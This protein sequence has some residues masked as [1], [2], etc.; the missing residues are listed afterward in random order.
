MLRCTN[1]HLIP[2]AMKRYSEQKE[3][4]ARTTPRNY[5]PAWELDFE[6]GVFDGKERNLNTQKSHKCFFSHIRTL[7][8]RIVEVGSFATFKQ[9]PPKHPFSHI[10]IDDI[11][12]IDPQRAG[13]ARAILGVAQDETENERD[14]EDGGDDEDDTDEGLDADDSHVAGPSG[15]H[16][17][18]KCKRK[19]RFS[20]TDCH[21]AACFQT[22]SSRELLNGTL[23]TAVITLSLY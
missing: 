22:A 2:V 4:S 18:Y 17:R 19:P 14:D 16:P 7:V 1:A 23:A 9:L 13:L 11:L 3:W 10:P 15:D 21:P 12:A 6:N 5:T 20:S 8:D